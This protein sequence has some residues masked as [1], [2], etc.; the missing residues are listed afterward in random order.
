VGCFSNNEHAASTCDPGLS[1][2]VDTGATVTYTAG[3]DAGYYIDYK[4]GG[5]WHL[6]WTCDTKLSAYGC[7]FTGTITVDTP[8]SGVNA[9][10]VMCEPAQDSLTVT[11]QGTQ[12][13]LAFDTVTTTGVDGVD[14]FAVAGNTIDVDLHVNG[15]YQ[16]D[17]VFLPSGGGVANATCMPIGLTPNKP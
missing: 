3:V 2:E 9:T 12:T 10:C 15:L 11:P 8:A 13:V 14:F 16:D 5:H 6:E 1:D 4:A 7:G 17:L